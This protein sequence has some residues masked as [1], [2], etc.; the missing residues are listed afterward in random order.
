M[1]VELKEPNWV[2]R[3]VFNGPVGVVLGCLAAIYYIVFG[4]PADFE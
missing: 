2:D 4:W 3:Y 1:S